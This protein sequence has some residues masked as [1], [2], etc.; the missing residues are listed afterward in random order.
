MLHPGTSSNRNPR[1]TLTFLLVCV[2]FFFLAFSSPS[3]TKAL[4]RLHSKGLLSRFVIDE[5]HC[6]S[7]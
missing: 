4:Q 3:M 7:E 6:V 1:A 5:A 2:G